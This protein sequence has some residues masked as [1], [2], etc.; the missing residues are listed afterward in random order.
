M[1]TCLHSCLSFQDFRSYKESIIEMKAR[2]Y[3]HTSCYFWMYF[4]WT[5][6]PCQASFFIYI[7]FL[8]AEL[9]G[10]WPGR[11]QRRSE[12]SIV[13]FGHGSLT[14]LSVSAPSLSFSLSLPLS[15][16]LHLSHPPPASQN[17][18][19]S[20]LYLFLCCPVSPLVYLPFP[21]PPTPPP[22]YLPVRLIKM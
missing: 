22:K 17:P 16:I 8:R 3:A 12:H 10:E 6:C 4:L 9:N 14:P 21:P 15:F 7:L 13:A 2:Q 18:S 19:Q 1:K 11:I 20:S 5:A